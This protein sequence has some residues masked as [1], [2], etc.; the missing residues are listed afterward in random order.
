[1]MKLLGLKPSHMLGDREVITMNGTRP[2]DDVIDT[3]LPEDEVMAKIQQAE[4]RMHSMKTADTVTM[5]ALTCVHVYR[6]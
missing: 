4:E 6:D 3:N 1:M 5:Y 2:F